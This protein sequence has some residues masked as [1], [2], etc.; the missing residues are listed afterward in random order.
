MTR[1]KT[2]TCKR[3]LNKWLVHEDMQPIASACPRCDNVHGIIW[4]PTDKT[5]RT[6]PYYA[7][8]ENKEEQIIFVPLSAVEY[9]PKRTLFDQDDDFISANLGW[10]DN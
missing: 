8:D 3:C 9:E 7:G 6:A 2:L 4:R 1:Y 5:T 10:E